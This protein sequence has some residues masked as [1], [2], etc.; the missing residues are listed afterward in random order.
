MARTETTGWLAGSLALCFVA[1]LA[2]AH[3][4][5]GQI[6]GVPIDPRTPPGLSVASYVSH[7]SAGT[8]DGLTFYGGPILRTGAL[9]FSGM[10]GVGYRDD[11]R[12][13]VVG[14]A[15]SL[16]MLSLPRHQPQPTAT[17]AL[18]MGI[19]WEF[20]DV[21]PESAV[22]MQDVPS[23]RAGTIGIVSSFRVPVAG[24]VIQPW[25][26][27]GVRAVAFNVQG[28]E[29]TLLPDLDGFGSTRPAFSAGFSFGLGER[30]TLEAMGE[31]SWIQV[32]D[33]RAELGY[34]REH[35]SLTATVGVRVHLTH[36]RTN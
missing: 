8:S 18:Q 13:P 29:G 24:T 28:V 5:H 16:S 30:A 35:D 3:T 12:Y 4:A 34:G 25:L 27:G 2:P 17:V 31:R 19:G 33:P 14:A 7:V 10:G 9:V 21:D 6:P 32:P 22:L 11:R 1:S 20:F 15:M 36:N 23:Q 26:S